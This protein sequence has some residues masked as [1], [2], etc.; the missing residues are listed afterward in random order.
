MWGCRWRAEQADKLKIHEG[1]HDF[2]AMSDSS[3]TKNKMRA[4]NKLLGEKLAAEQGLKISAEQADKLKIHEDAH[5]E[6]VRSFKATFERW[7]D[8]LL[9]KTTRRGVKA[10]VVVNLTISTGMSLVN[11][12]VPDR[13]GVTAFIATTYHSEPMRVRA[14]AAMPESTHGGSHVYVPP[15]YGC[16]AGGS[17]SQYGSNDMQLD[18]TVQNC[19]RVARDDYIKFGSGNDS[20]YL[21]CPASLGENMLHTILKAIRKGTPTDEVNITVEKQSNDGT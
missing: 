9:I 8:H 7:G 15:L 21:L 10:V 13:K 1:A 3:A 11:G 18:F 4:D 14:C 2:K 19:A 17:G 6:D 12:R 20:Y 5:A 16:G